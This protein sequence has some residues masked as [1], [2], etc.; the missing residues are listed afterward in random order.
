MTRS[1]FITGAARGIGEATALRL[2]A[3]GWLVGAYDISPDIGLLSAENVHT[4]HIDVTSPESW[5]A[6]L[7]DFADA[8]G[9]ID[10]VVNNAGTLYGGSFVDDG[11]Y[12]QDAAL[13]DV[14]VKG[15]CYGMRAAYPYLRSRGGGKVIN[16]SS[17][18]S[19]YGTPEMATYSA[20]KFAVRGITEALEV[21]WAGQNIAV[22]SVVPLYA[23]TGMLDGVM[24]N[25]M[26]RLGVSLT[27]DDI[28][29]VI[30]QL[31]SSP[32]RSGGAVHHPVGFK[33]TLMNACSQVTP[34]RL[35]RY[36][37]SRLTSG[38]KISF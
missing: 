13:I 37:N 8:A 28:A 30:V 25:G 31:A 22:N 24:T 10:V 18:A 3:E 34:A 20:T 29:S 7:T 16:L 6:A 14:N 12:E 32:H 17:A 27:A 19:I 5:E 35:L 15:T 11:S 26:K 1:V 4:G 33:T 21:E 23:D 36:V 38:V 2:A 9:G